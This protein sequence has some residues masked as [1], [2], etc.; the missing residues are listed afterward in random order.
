MNNDKTSN[1]ESK[2]D[3]DRAIAGISELQPG[4]LHQKAILFRKL[5]PVIEEAL[6]RNVPQKHIVDFLKKEGLSL[7][8][9][10]F[11]SL[12][13]AERKHQKTHERTASCMLPSAAQP[14]LQED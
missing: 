5:F 13:E 1:S 4:K 3:T 2:F 9:G 11:R 12:L 8:I 14:H 10:G 7:S 6:A